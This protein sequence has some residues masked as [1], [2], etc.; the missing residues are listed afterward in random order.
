MVCPELD[1]FTVHPLSFVST[2]DVSF[3]IVLELQEDKVPLASQNKAC[4]ESK[5]YIPF[6]YP[7]FSYQH[8]AIF[9]RGFRHSNNTSQKASLKMLNCISCEQSRPVLLTWGFLLINGESPEPDSPCQISLAV[10]ESKEKLD[11][12]DDWLG[13]NSKGK[14][15][16]V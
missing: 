1:L 16:A 2:S 5:I 8:R 7:E 15:K 12:L 13:T 11:R 14:Q 4:S 3:A 9:L 10:Q 6:R